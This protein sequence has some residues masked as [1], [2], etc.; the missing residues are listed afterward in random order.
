MGSNTISLWLAV[1]VSSLSATTFGYDT[2]V[3]GGVLGFASFQKHFNITAAESA[4]LNGNVVSLLQ[5]GCLVGALSANFFGDRFG[6]RWSVMG[7]SVVFIVGGILQ[8]IGSDIGMLYAGRILAGFGIGANSCLVPIYIAEISPQNLRGKLGTLWQV[9]IVF[10]IAI[11]Y[12]INYACKRTIASDNDLLWRLPLG[13]QCL[14]AVLVFIGMIPL[15]ETPRWLIA[16]GHD[17]KAR[18][19]LRFLRGQEAEEEFAEISEGLRAE[20][21]LGPVK[22]TDVIS[23]SN[24]KRLFIGCC[25]QMFQ[26]LTGSNV[27]NYYSPTIFKSIGLSGDEADLLAT[28]LYGTLKI[29]VTLFTAFFITDRVG[30][31]KPLIFGG[32][33]MAI[34]MFMVGAMVKI[35]PLQTPDASIGATSYVG[36]VFIFM[37]ACVYSMSWGPVVWVY[38]SE[39]FPTNIRAQAGSLYTAINWAFNA[40]IGKVGPLLLASI[41]YGTYFLF[42]SFC[43][44]MA[45]YTF[46]LVPETKGIMLEAMP[47]LFQG[48]AYQAKQLRA[49]TDA[50]NFSDEHLSAS[51]ADKN[52]FEE[53][54]IERSAM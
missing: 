7:Y 2:G 9:F 17:D 8:T 24:R 6:R 35:M 38:T 51:S 41:V 36:V 16:H 37:F 23:K 22:W 25:L 26:I 10:G 11:S 42:G 20:S 28:G 43:I 40:I 54:R 30:R 3:I 45:I 49:N 32:I 12:W 13:L 29:F 21:A 52:N 47:E 19:S 34:C 48:S 53:E 46:F 15:T 14:W 39:I 5:V 44:I 33:G 31:R 4:N 27:I 18:K 50:E 1:C